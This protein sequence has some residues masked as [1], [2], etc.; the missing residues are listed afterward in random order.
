MQAM[1]QYRAVG[2]V[3]P[4]YRVCLPPWKGAMAICQSIA[5]LYSFQVHF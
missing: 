1:I 2:T 4:R 5:T 3:H